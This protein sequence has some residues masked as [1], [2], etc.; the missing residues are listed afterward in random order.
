MTF[1]VGYWRNTFARRT[2]VIL[3]FLFFVVWLPVLFIERDLRT[4]EDEAKEQLRDNWDL[5]WRVTK[6][7]WEGYR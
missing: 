5:L 1:Q 6:G 3:A 4:S 7:A 2:A